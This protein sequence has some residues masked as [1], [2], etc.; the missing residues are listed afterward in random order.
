[1][2]MITLPSRMSPP[3]AV[4]VV[5]RS[6]TWVKPSW[7]AASTTANSMAKNISKLPARLEG[8]R[9]PLNMRCMPSLAGS[10]SAPTF[11]SSERSSMAA[12]RATYQVSSTMTTAAMMCGTAVRNCCSMSVA[13]RLMASIFRA[14]SAAI[15]AGT[16][17]MM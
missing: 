5:S 14:S 7:L 11:C 8:S 3:K 4:K 9:L 10:A 17:T 12:K 16:S 6:L 15:S 2:I 13:G 1:M